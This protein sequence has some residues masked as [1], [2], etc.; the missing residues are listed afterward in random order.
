M[1]KQTAY[2]MLLLAL[3]ACSG[4]RWNETETCYGYNVITQK[5]GQTLAYSPASGVGILTEDG[6]AFKD[7]NRNGVLDP[8]EDWRL[9][10]ETRADDEA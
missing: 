1:K 3:A 6:Y 10:A 5:K 2:A 4:P 8:Y 9:P 7:M